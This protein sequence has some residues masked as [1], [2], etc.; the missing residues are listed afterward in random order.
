MAFVS[1]PSSWLQVGQPLTF[2]LMNRI[3]DNLE[4]LNSRLDSVSIAAGSNIL[5]N[6]ILEKPR[7]IHPVGSV[8]FSSLSEAEF[9]S[10]IKDGE[11][12]L[13]D[14]SNVAGSDWA[15]LTGK[16]TLP[17]LR[18][19]FIRAKSHSSGNN[20]SGDKALDS[21]TGD[22]IGSHSHSAGSLTAD[23]SGAH[24]HYTFDR[25][26]AA[27]NSQL[28][29]GRDGS[30]AIYAASTNTLP[31]NPDRHY[32]IGGITA[33][34]SGGG[35]NAGVTSSDGAHTHAVAGSTASAGGSE[36]SP[37]YVTENAFIKINK[38][39]IETTSRL[40]VMR[41]DQTTRINQVLIT[42]VSQGTSGNFKINIKKGPTPALATQTIF[43]GTTVPTLAYNDTT[44][45]SA[46][47]DSTQ[48]EILAGE[49]IVV[50][51]TEVQSKMEAVHIFVS[52]DH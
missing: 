14:G 50:S 17:D 52:G 51:I 33:A 42:P 41:I 44:S 1:V 15:A 27:T 29:T 45:K 23:S 9:L 36:T 18:G 31:G 19:R 24:D 11:W 21:F 46:P 13:A 49:F 8:I 32:D 30:A 43:V 34:G 39:Y 6:G 38:E 37:G 40:L 26:S 47:T 4:D 7:D 28:N 22:S 48:S 12:K 16:T 25:D 35:P 2:G 10:E 20:P 5:A 3:N